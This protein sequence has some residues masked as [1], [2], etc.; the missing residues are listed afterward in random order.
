MKTCK[1]L[2]AVLMIAL[3][4]ASALS[5]ATLAAAVKISD[6]AVTCAK[7]VSYTGKALKPSVKVVY[8]GKTL[9]KDTDYTLAY[10]SNTNVGTGKVTVKGKSGFTGSTTLS[11]KIVMAAPTG[12][13]ASAVKASSAKLSWTKV[14]GAVKYGVYSYNASTKKYTKLM[15]VKATSA[16]VE[17]SPAKAYQ[18]AVKAFDKNNNASSASERVAVNTLPGTPSLTL[19]AAGTDSIKLSWSK[20]AGAQGYKIYSY[21]DKTKKFTLLEVVK[22]ASTL[23]FTKTGLKA[24]TTY[25]YAVAAYYKAGSSTVNGAKSATQYMCTKPGKVTG[26]KATPTGA[27]T[28]S[29]SWNAVSGTGG[30]TV[31]SYDASTKKY[32]KL[33]TSS[34]ASYSV[35]GLKNET[36][37]TF[38]VA[39]YKKVS[40]ATVYG[41]KSAKA[42]A[43]TLKS[44]ALS[45]FQDMINAGKYTIKYKMTASGETVTAKTAVSGGTVSST[46]SSTIDGVSATMYMWYNGSKKT[47]IVKAKA[48]GLGFYDTFGEKEAKENGLDANSIKMLFAP[49]QAAGADVITGKAT[50][51]ST[52]CTTYIYP[53]EGGGSMTYYF[54][55][56]GKLLQIRSGSD[57]I[58]ITS[59]SASVSSSDIK[60]P[61]TLGCVKM[62]DLF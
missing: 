44:N 9:K 4:L 36:K 21:V 22:S 47:G 48:M 25:A 17:L 6:C 20:A 13:K 53:V 30:Y 39:A 15:V 19:S 10:S 55:N 51:G 18:L 57:L 32:T 31:Y 28:V 41:A 58:T 1:K 14:A 42:A 49:P 62:D 8:D 23:S 26:L 46:M 16:T 2:L 43:T 11:F 5:V 52:E 38:A 59:Y 35:S 50:V 54:N 37:Y 29:L 45:D 27:S 61:S 60:K 24:A 12:V 7:Q 3:T 33:G 56:S 40:G 34:S